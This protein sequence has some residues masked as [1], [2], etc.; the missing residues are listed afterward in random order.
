MRCRL[1]YGFCLRT[2]RLCV[3]SSNAVS[4]VNG[5]LNEKLKPLGLFLFRFKELIQQIAGW[6]LVG[7]RT[8]GRLIDVCV[9]GL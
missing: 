4:A 6:R 9:R 7:G 5:D 8:G 1:N 2:V 3:E